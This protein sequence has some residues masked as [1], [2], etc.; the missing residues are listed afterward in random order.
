MPQKTT[1]AYTQ[2]VPT[3]RLDEFF[4]GPLAASGIF[5]D[6]RRRVRNRFFMHLFGEWAG[7][8]GTLEEYFT[9]LD[10]HGHVT[11]ADRIWKLE[12]LNQNSFRGTAKGNAGDLVGMAEGSSEG[13]AMH[14]RYTVRQPVGDKHYNLRTDDRM[15]RLNDTCV[16]NHSRMH[17]MGIFVGEAIIEIHRLPDA[18]SDQ[19]RTYPAPGDYR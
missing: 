18:C 6:R 10:D 8:Y 2:T 1:H 4:S 17:F 14:W 3:F 15:Y 5:V 13:Y 7:S 12:I 9:F 11:H 19:A 16:T